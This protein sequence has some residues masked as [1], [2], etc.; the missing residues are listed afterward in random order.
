MKKLFLLLFCGF[1]ILQT[2]AQTKPYWQDVQVV[3][4]NKEYPRSSF[5]TYDNLEQALSF[6]YENSKFYSLLNGTWKFYFVDGYK[7]CPPTSPTL[8][9]PRQTGKTYRC[10]ATGNPR[11]T[12]WLSTPTTVMNSSPAIRNHRLFRKKIRSVFTAG[13]SIY[14]QSGWTGIFT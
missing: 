4:V 9:F 14:R 12:E 8:P 11:V 2:M 10:R 1:C 13:T 6:K 7:S 3:A 5:M